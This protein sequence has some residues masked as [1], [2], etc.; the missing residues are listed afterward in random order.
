MATD[1]QRASLKYVDIARSM[2]SR[3]TGVPEENIY[4]SAS[5]THAG[6]DVDNGAEETVVTYLS[7]LCVL[8]R[9]VAVAAM[10]DR[11][12]ARMYYGSIETKYMNFVRHYKHTA[13]D[14]TVKYFGDNFGTAV[15]DKTTEHATEVDPTLHVIRFDRE[16]IKAAGYSDTVAVLL[17]NSDDL[18]GVECGAQ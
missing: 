13:A 15:L 16:K 2:I 9:N 11:E 1:L 7:E 17:T 3:E 18:E 5:H 12:P 10:E 6:P 4:I 8:L 14:G